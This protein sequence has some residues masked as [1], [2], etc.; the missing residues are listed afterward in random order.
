MEWRTLEKDWKWTGGGLQVD[1]M[2]YIWTGGGLHKDPWG[3]V[4]YSISACHTNYHNNFSIHGGIR[5][6]YRG[7]PDLIQVGEHQFVERSQMHAWIGLTTVPY[8]ATAVQNTVSYGCGPYRNRTCTCKPI[9]TRRP[10]S[11][12]LPRPASSPG[13][14]ASGNAGAPRRV[15]RLLHLGC[16]IAAQK[17]RIPSGNRF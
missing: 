7:I 3:S 11:H 8:T 4:R 1:S 13:S 12:P 14:T 17:R 6:Y 9:P 2:D 16:A 10:T 5:T 15:W